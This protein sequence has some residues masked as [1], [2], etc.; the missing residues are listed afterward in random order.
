MFYLVHLFYWYR[1]L[2]TSAKGGQGGT[3]YFT[4]VIKH[5]SAIL[6]SSLC[7]IKHFGTFNNINRRSTTIIIIDIYYILVTLCILWLEIWQKKT[8]KLQIVVQFDELI[9]ISNDLSFDIVSL[10]YDGNKKNKTTSPYEN[11]A[12]AMRNDFNAWLK[13]NDDFY[14]IY[15][16]YNLNNNNNDC[17]QTFYLDYDIILVKIR[18]QIIY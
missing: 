12:A 2:V 13:N 8:E 7:V 4:S 16:K 14:S 17:N 3:G 6:T 1:K 9:N 10:Q 5:F 11:F 18:L 15:S